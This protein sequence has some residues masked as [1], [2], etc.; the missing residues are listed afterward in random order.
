MESTTHEVAPLSSATRTQSET[1]TNSPFSR[2]NFNRRDF[3]KLAFG[4]CA[5]MVGLQTQRGKAGEPDIFSSDRKSGSIII[6][7]GSTTPKIIIDE[8][9]RR[10]TSASG[11]V[12]LL[13]V[14]TAEK[15][16]SEHQ[17]SLDLWRKNVSDRVKDGI[18]N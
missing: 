10:A 18:V 9:C 13:V 11:K 1:V 6:V 4:L 17:V 3:H 14:P 16:E 12:N 8:I 15:N 2:V 5:G 7:G